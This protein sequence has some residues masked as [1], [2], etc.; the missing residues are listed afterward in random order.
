MCERWL[1]RGSVKPQCMSMFPDTPA[2]HCLHHSALQQEFMPTRP[3][4]HAKQSNARLALW[5]QITAAIL[6][7]PACCP[8]CPHL[9]MAAK[10][11]GGGL[12]QQAQ[13]AMR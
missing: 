12:Y 1:L 2:A 6:R 10:A 7:A 11:Q 9:R 13:I 3:A 4:M 8:V 5:A